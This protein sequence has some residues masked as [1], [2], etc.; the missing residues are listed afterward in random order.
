MA[1]ADLARGATRRRQAWS[2]NFSRGPPGQR[3]VLAHSLSGS[4]QR[5]DVVLLHGGGPGATGA[6][7]YAKNVEALLSQHRCW[8]IDFPG[9]GSSSKNLNAFGGEGRFRRR[10]GGAGVHGRGRIAQRT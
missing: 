5:A 7:N 9:W 2:S 4:G 10:T 8:V 6:S 1:A 3:R